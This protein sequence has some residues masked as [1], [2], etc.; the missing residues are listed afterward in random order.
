MRVA[1]AFLVLILVAPEA[2]AKGYTIHA[3]GGEGPLYFRPGDLD[4]DEGERVTLT[5]VN[6]DPGTPH[7][8]ALLGYGGRDIEV[9]VKG[10]QTRTI[11][12]TASETGEYRIVCQVVGHKQRGMEG[13]LTV[14][15]KLLAPGVGLAPALVAL[16][17]L[18][19]GI[20][21]R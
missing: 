14:D 13:T 10:G 16:A 1:L 20:R 3:G 2:A 11:N 18:A 7:D 15:N 12:F 8:W 5:L 9:Y 17:L 6:D 4:V 21:R 19:F